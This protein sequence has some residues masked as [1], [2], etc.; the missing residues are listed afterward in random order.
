[1]T[2]IALGGLMGNFPDLIRPSD[3][4][5]SDVRDLY[6]I[7]SFFAVSGIV[8][9]VVAYGLFRRKPWD[10][11]LA[12]AVS[13]LAL[14][15]MIVSWLLETIEREDYA[16]ILSFYSVPLVL[17]LSW[18]IAEAVRQLRERKAMTGA[19]GQGGQIA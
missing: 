13:A 5:P 15:L 4:P 8:F 12:A 7:I 2:L 10:S 16:I 19:N 14:A 17:T 18:S 3:L 11:Y 9:L 6:F 1:M